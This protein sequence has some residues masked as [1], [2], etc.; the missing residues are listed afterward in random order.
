MSMNMT[1]R[2]FLK[3]A[4]A[5]SAAV[6]ASGLL[7]GF[8]SDGNIIGNTPTTMTL[9]DYKVD[10]AVKKSS[11]TSETKDGKKTGIVVPMVYITNKGSSFELKNFNKVFQA[12]TSDGVELKLSTSL[13]QVSL[14]QNVPATVTPTFTTTDLEALQKLENGKSSLNLSITLSG[15]TAVYTM[16]FKDLTQEVKKG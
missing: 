9:G 14:V 7:G 4:G 13:K 11:L 16:N 8:S 10:V 12:K 1:R 3:T 5:V 2:E 6:A 15:Q